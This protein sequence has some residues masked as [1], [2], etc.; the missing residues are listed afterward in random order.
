MKIDSIDRFIKRLI[1]LSGLPG[2]TIFRKRLS[3]L[4]YTFKR[5]L[6][7]KLVD[8]FQCKT[9]IETGTSYGETTNYIGRYCENVLSCEPDPVLFQIARHRFQNSTNIKLWNEPS[10]TCLPDMIDHVVGR[11]LFWLDGHFQGRVINSALET[12]V[13]YE[14]DSIKRLRGGG[15]VIVVDDVRLFDSLQNRL[16]STFSLPYPTIDCT[17]RLLKEI[18]PG[19]LIT[20]SGDCLLS[21]PS[22][23]L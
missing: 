3:P 8:Q 4:G 12:P 18:S 19:N 9:F 14:L 5:L 15:D 1:I 6:L 23:K 13:L 22:D 10:E 2:T 17:V 21:M 20:I 7:R 16:Q 11:A